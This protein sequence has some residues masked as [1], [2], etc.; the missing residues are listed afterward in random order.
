MDVRGVWRSF[1]G[2][3]PHNWVLGVERVISR[4]LDHFWIKGIVG[5]RN[6]RPIRRLRAGDVATV[7]GIWFHMS[8]NGGCSRERREI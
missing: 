1:L 3:E 6:S 8:P 2:N 4:N 7:G 5:N